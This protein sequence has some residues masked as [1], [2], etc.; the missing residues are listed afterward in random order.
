MLALARQC[1][2][3]PDCDLTA[4][5]RL[6]AEPAYPLS[7][8][9][10]SFAWTV[11]DTAIRR[12][13]TL[14]FLIQSFLTQPIGELEPRL[15]AVLLAGSAQILFMDKAPPHAAINHAVE[16]AKTVI[17]PGAGNLANAVLR[18]VAGLIAADRES[19]RRDR[20]TEAPNEFPLES[21]GAIALSQ[22]VLPDDPVERLALATSC[23]RTLIDHWLK[24]M[25][26]GDVRRQALHALLRPPVV[27]NVRHASSP[28]P[29]GLTPHESPGHAVWTGAV[30]DL[31]ALLRS[32]PDIWVQDAASSLAV[33]STIDLQPRLIVDACAGQGTK[34]RQ[35]LA[36]FPDAQVIASDADATRVQTLRE[37]FAHSPR[38]RVIER[39]DLLLEVSAQADLVLLDVP[40]SNTGVLARRPE[41]KHRFDAAHLASLVSVQKQ[42]IADSIALLREAPRG[43]ILYSTCS[44]EAEENHAQVAWADRWHS[45]GI[46]RERQDRPRAIP[47]DALTSYADGSYSALLG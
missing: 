6:L 19:A 28:L 42:I 18:K 45:L 9:D 39:R 26:F 29:D 11:Y 24:S 25:P 47:G 3:W 8:L 31:S 17:R 30:T 12:Y 4:L 14:A 44:I 22:S 34:T 46:S 27:L 37:R 38:V 1:K 21:G 43:R 33:D 5:D 36:V 40:C 13:S 35:L 7:E 15:R 10:R 23:P 2:L 20:W 16:W 32:R 41:A